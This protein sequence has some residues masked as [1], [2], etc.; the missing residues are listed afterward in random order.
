MRPQ[1]A[2]VLLSCLL[3]A[4]CG[5]IRI[6][7][8]DFA[9]LSTKERSHFRAFSIADAGKTVSYA[10]SCVLQTINHRN[11]SELSRQYPVLWVRYFAP[12]CPAET[13]EDIGAYQRKAASCGPNVK[14][15]L[16]SLSYAHDEL[17]AKLS[18][19]GIDKMVYVLDTC[20]SSHFGTAMR[21][22]YAGVK[23]GLPYSS[24][25]HADD[26]IIRNDSVVYMK[27]GRKPDSVFLAAVRRLGQGETLSA[28][29]W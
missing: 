7:S 1:L 25:R 8:N 21:Q 2:Y 24:F 9:D 15:V 5:V 17:K 14:L 19:S 23:Q 22:M 3:F 4:G 10:D 27:D 12:W 6:N 11:L 29:V 28:Q 18:R 26:F 16:V 13:C 20:Y